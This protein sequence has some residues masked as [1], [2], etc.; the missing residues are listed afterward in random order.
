VSL[1]ARLDRSWSL[2][3]REVVGVLIALCLLE[4][5]ALGLYLRTVP[6]EVT[7]VRYF[8]YPFVWVN[9]AVVAVARTRIPSASTRRH[10]LVALVGVGYFLGL[11]AIDGTLA[12][13]PGTG[14]TVH[15]ALPPGWGPLVIAD[16][17]P[18]RLTPVPYR[19]LGYAAIAYLLSVTLLERSLRGLGGLVGLF[20]CVSCTLPVIAAVLSGV[21]G[22][23]V[24]A[25]RVRMSGEIGSK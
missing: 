1:A 5:L 6:A 17:G 9:V 20:S 3:R 4:A 21:A 10:T 23:S 7:A 2:P 18:V 14:L 8:L 25:G 12:L 19:T 16:V 11:A 15:W 22:G 24:I 13:S